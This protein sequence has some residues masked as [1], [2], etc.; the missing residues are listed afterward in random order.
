MSEVLTE[1]QHYKYICSICNKEIQARKSN[2]PIRTI[3]RACYSKEILK[4]PQVS[5]KG[6]IDN[7]Q[8]GDVR[9]GYELGKLNSAHKYHKFIYSK[10]EVCGL[11]RW[12][13][14]KHGKPESAICN[15]CK[16]HGRKG[17][18]HPNW[19]DTERRHNFRGYVMIRLSPDDFFYP[20]C[21]RRGWVFEHRLVMAKSLGRNL[22][23]WE[24]VHHKNHI[25]DDNRIENLQLVS[26]DKHKQFTALELKIDRLLNKQDELMKEIKL[27]RFENRQLKENSAWRP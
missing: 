2:A 19:I 9:H 14:L 5:S 21:S 8:L 15:H 13:I 27:L 12:S 16:W 20:S 4:Y 23:L 26:D 17:S 24:I 22:H 25:R 6:T 7:P 10:C 11:Q 1:N 18:N 3:C